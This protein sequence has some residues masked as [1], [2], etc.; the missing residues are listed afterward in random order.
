MH[1]M[2]YVGIAVCT[3]MPVCVCLLFPGQPNGLE[4]CR[5]RHRQEGE[6][7]IAPTAEEGAIPNVLPLPRDKLR[8]MPTDRTNRQG[9]A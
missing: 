3:C 4:R 2:S 1:N 8:L 9:P 7:R 6:E 5:R